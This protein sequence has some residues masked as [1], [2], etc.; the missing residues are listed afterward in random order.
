MVDS[1]VNILKAT[2]VNTLKGWILCY[3]NCIEQES[4]TP[5]YEVYM[6]NINNSDMQGFRKCTIHAPILKKLLKNK[7][8]ENRFN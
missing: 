6:Q 7:H 2:E 4:K 3:V 5:I 8:W 1:F